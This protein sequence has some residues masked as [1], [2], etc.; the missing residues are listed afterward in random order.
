VGAKVVLDGVSR[1]KDLAA[2]PQWYALLTR[3]FHKNIR[4]CRALLLA[5]PRN[6]AWKEPTGARA[7]P[8]N[9]NLLAEWG[10]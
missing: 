4:G 9:I 2:V 7:P 6:P 5:F 1:G 8:P 3:L 10:I